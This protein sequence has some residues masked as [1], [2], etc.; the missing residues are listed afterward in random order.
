M[1]NE[2]NL[3]AE[4]ESPQSLISGDS[5]LSTKDGDSK[6]IESNAENES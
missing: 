1:L 3:N 5:S 4:N 2:I 6:N